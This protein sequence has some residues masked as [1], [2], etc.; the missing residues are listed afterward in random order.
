MKETIL[1]KFQLNSI[2]WQ[3]KSA[4]IAFLLFLWGITPPAAAHHALAGRTPGNF[5]AG[6]LSGLAHPIIGAD[7]FAFVVAVGLLAAW[8]PKGGRWLAVA[9]IFATLGGTSFHLLGLHLPAAEVGIAVSVL[10]F[11]ILLA[12]ENRLPL[13]WL[14]ALA[15]AAGVWHGYAYGEA[16]MG[17]EMTPLVAY[18]AGFALIQLVV[19]LAAYKIGRLMFKTSAS[20]PSLNLRFAGFAIAGAGAAFLSSAIFG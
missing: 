8:Q 18:L 17:A 3:F 15:A 11:G 20:Q 19:A 13:S 1:S 12:Q 6:F 5:W 2:P 16:I 14:L 4:G 10:L 7:H 9:F